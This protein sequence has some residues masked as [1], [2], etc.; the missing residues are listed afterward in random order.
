MTYRVDPTAE[1][2]AIAHAIET[3]AHAEAEADRL[4]PTGAYYTPHQYDA[5]YAHQYEP[6]PRGMF[7]P[8]AQGGADHARATHRTGSPIVSEWFHC[9]G[10]GRLGHYHGRHDAMPQDTRCQRCK[11][12]DPGGTPNPDPSQTGG[13]SGRLSAQAETDGPG[14]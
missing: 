3:K 11:D 14:G 7:P 13:V 12:T 2:V 10:C 4:N 8:D 5:A 1:A 6:P 9:P